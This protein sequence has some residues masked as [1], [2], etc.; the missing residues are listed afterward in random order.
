MVNY[1]RSMI[2]KEEPT[3]IYSFSILHYEKIKIALCR[4][5]KDN[6]YFMA[7][8][9]FTDSWISKNFAGPNVSELNN[10]TLESIAV[11][12]SFDTLTECNN[13]VPPSEEHIEFC[14]DKM[15]GAIEELF[16]PI[17]TR[18]TFGDDFTYSLS[19]SPVPTVVVTVRNKSELV[20][21]IAI[22]NNS[23]VYPVLCNSDRILNYVAQ[24]R[25]ESTI[26]PLCLGK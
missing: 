9:Y 21:T 10:G 24:I 11:V 3:Y 23:V 7:Y 16:S 18:N 15:R 4:Y 13:A 1:F 19:L 6:R 8:S 5:V 14:F 22:L 2:R 25:G 26:S 20:G 12:E 17:F